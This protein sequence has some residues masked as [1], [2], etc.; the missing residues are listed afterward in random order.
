MKNNQQSIDGFTPRRRVNSLS[1]ENDKKRSRDPVSKTIKQ[2]KNQLKKPEND[3]KEEIELALQNLEI[4]ENQENERRER[5]ASKR[6]QKLLRK[7]EKKNVK[8][9]K[10]NKKPLSI[11]QFKR[12]RVIRRIFLLILIIIVAFG[13][14]KVYKQFNVL[15]KITNGNVISAII[16]KKK[17]KSDSNGR[18]NI[19]IFG[20]SPKGWD[21]ENLTDSVMVASVNQD[22]KKIYT[23]SLPRDLWVKHTCR[24][25]L[26]TTAGKLNETYGCAYYD[27]KNSGSSEGAAEKAGQQ[28]LASTAKD[29]LG[30]D[31]QY[32][33]HGNWKVLIDSINAVGGVDVLVEAY[34]G[35][36]RVYDV[37]TKIN[38]VSGQT[39]HMDGNTALAFSRARGSEGG[40][41]LS[42]SNFDR[43]RNQQKILKAAFAKI[44]QQKMNPIALMAIVESLGE[45][46]HHSFEATEL[47]TAAELAQEF[48][49][50][51]IT[52]L[53]LINEKDAD[54]N[55]FSTGMIGS[56]SAVIP[57]AGTYDYSQ[58]Q[59]YI[60]KNTVGGE[61]V[62]ENAKI[63]VLNGTNYSGLAAQEQKVLKKEGLNIQD[64]DSTPKRDYKKTKIYYSEKDSKPA[65]I[66]KLELKYSTK[67]EKLPTDLSKFGENSDIII[68]L[69]EDNGN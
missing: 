23:V 20:T 3:S 45:N 48:N 19:L 50:G 49:S 44:N 4:E 62:K 30:L 54:A 52:S 29:I 66:K 18:T 22:S 8:R 33:I 36:K 27:A 17:L 59:A 43:E 41:G 12:R 42:G 31:I 67:S 40:V 25:W 1:Q 53:P 35:S 13:G 57:K 38:Y 60:S 32:V 69:G 68:V 34:D 5:M 6:Q 61:I 21:G 2:E 39:Y 47:R 26:G 37:A 56:V 16:E 55:Y 63:V 51:E 65:T 24:T 58:I 7:L 10:K 64:I 14:Y 9:E 11:E 46:V 15:N 28:A